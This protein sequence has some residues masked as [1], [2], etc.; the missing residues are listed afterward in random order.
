MHRHLI[1]ALVGACLCAASLLAQPIP[2]QEPDPDLLRRALR[3]G[4]SRELRVALREGIRSHTTGDPRPLARIEALLEA[5]EDHRRVGLL[6]AALDRRRGAE[7]SKAAAG[8]AG[9]IRGRLRDASSGLPLDFEFV[10]LYDSLG[11]FVDLEFTDEGDYV[12]E[13]VPAGSY[14]VL[15]DT[16]AHLDELYA[17]VPCPKGACDVTAGTPVEVTQEAGAT[18]IDFELTRGGRILGKVTDAAT[19]LPLFLE[20][21]EVVNALGDPVALDFTDSAGSFLIGG[22]PTGTYFAR[23]DADDHLDELYAGVSCPLSACDVTSGTPIAVTLDRDTTGIDFA[24]DT[25]GRIL[26]QV[27]ER[28]TGLPL[29]VQFVFLFDALGKAIDLDLTGGGGDYLFGGLPAGTYYAATE[30]FGEYF[31]EL[32][33]D[34]PCPDETCD[35]T[36][37]TPIAVAPAADTTG[38]DFVLSVNGPSEVPRLSERSGFV[39]PVLVDL[40]D[41]AG[42]T[43]LFALNNTSDSALTLDV[44]YYTARVGEEPVR[45][46]QVT[47]AAGATTTYDVRSRL[48]G[49]DTSGLEQL[50]GLV[51]ISEQGRAVAPELVGDSFSVDFSADFASGAALLRARDLCNRQRIRLVDFGSGT[52]LQVLLNEPR[53]AGTPSFSYTAWDSSGAVIGSG[54]VFADEH[55]LLLEGSDLASEPFGMLEVDFGNAVGGHVSATYSAFGRF[56]VGVGGECVK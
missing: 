53:G 14:F 9:S 21:V 6:R 22:L 24:L 52:E 29:G 45:T 54:D 41:P 42:R 7:R 20:I 32:Y 31:D 27:S 10:E 37:G 33:D 38:I 25:G 48:A 3:P 49:Y 34:V 30:T 15:T 19:G 40:T 28:L 55:F 12:F 51:L 13:D 16:D 35:P 44:D 50:A 43:T 26:G 8:P 39:V 17:D 36:A 18:G 2:S 56:S 4:M 46:D 47:L 11:R 1:L 5:E 23:A